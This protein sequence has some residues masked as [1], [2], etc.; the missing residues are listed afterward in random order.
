MTIHLKTWSDLA[1]F[2]RPEMKVERVSF[3]VDGVWL[4]DL[5][6]SAQFWR[7]WRKKLKPSSSSTKRVCF[8]T[9]ELIE[10]VETSG[11][12]KGLP[13]GNQS[14]TIFLSFHRD[15]FCSF[16]LQQG[17]NAALSADAEM[18]IRSSLSQLIERSRAQKLVF[19]NTIFLHWTRKP[20]DFDPVDLLAAA[21]ENPEAVAQLLESVQDGSQLVAFD[22]NAYYAVS[23]S[24]NGAGIVVRDWLEST[25]PKIR[26]HVAKWF[27]DI[28]IVEPGGRASRSVEYQHTDVWAFHHDVSAWL[29]PHPHFKRSRRDLEAMFPEPKAIAAC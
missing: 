3:T 9:G 26:D 2:T 14:G 13:G 28:G 4:L 7:S 18:K 10:A 15:A 24:G 8:A 29:S 19:N 6:E 25:V 21:N 16:G 11:V 22:A 1:C 27:L 23:L 5:T 12:I 17:Q 20:V